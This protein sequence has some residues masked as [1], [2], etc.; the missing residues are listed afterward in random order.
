MKKVLTNEDLFYIQ[1]SY[2]EKSIQEISIELNVSKYIVYMSM[3]YLGIFNEYKKPWTEEED[4]Y[5]R[6]HWNNESRETIAKKLNKN[7]NDIRCRIFALKLKRPG[8]INYRYKGTDVKYSWMWTEDEIQYL[9]NEYSKLAYKDIA[10]HLNCSEHSILAMANHLNLKKENKIARNTFNYYE[11][12]IIKN[13]YGKISNK[14]LIEKLN[15]KWNENAIN[16]KASELGVRKQKLTLPERQVQY[17]L[18]KNNILYESQKRIYFGKQYYICD[19]VIEKYIIEVQGDYWH[20]NPIIYKNKKLNKTQE[21]NIKNDITKKEKLERI[22]YK[23][24]YIWEYDLKNFFNKVEKQ[25][26]ATL[27]LR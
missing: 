4:L 22:G 14:E 24:I 13:F 21:K 2:K 17:I 1:N 11:I 15:N 3:Y 7:E 18:E 20:A 8:E 19:F 27:K 12:E 25:L 10:K 23:I 9:K 6:Q 5:L 26:I 16:K